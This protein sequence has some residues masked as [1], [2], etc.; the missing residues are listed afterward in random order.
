M[1]SLLEYLILEAKDD[2]EKGQLPSGYEEIDNRGSI[3]KV[4]REAIGGTIK[5]AE[6]A[7]KTEDGKKQIKIKLDVTGTN[8][9]IYDTITKIALAKNEL[10]ALLDHN[11]MQPIGSS[12]I[13]IQLVGDWPALAGAPKSSL[14]LI[15]FWMK[16]ALIA[17]GAPYTKDDVVYAYSK[18]N[19]GKLLIQLRSELK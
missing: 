8:S 4:A 18:D 13:E 17:Y 16:S 1:K 3:T 9:T 5:E 19:G 2:K 10:D 11:K 12:G 7:A 15:K 6:V 14:K